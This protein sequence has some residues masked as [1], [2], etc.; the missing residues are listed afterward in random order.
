MANEEHFRKLERTYLAAPTNAYYF[1]DVVGGASPV[2]VERIRRNPTPLLMVATDVRSDAPSVFSSH[3]IPA[4]APRSVG[5]VVTGGSDR[6]LRVQRTSACYS[7]HTGCG[8][9]RPYPR[10]KSR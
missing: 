10:R 9:Y 6:A 7:S 1:D 2:D 3:D 5:Q 8:P 4:T